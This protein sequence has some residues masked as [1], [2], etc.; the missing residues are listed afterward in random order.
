[1]DVSHKFVDYQQ[2]VT[3]L[4]LFLLALS[5]FLLPTKECQG[6]FRNKFCSGGISGSDQLFQSL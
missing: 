2:G 6:L 5:G 4:V 3:P 1:M